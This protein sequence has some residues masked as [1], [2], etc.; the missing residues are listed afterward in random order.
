MLASEA[1]AGLDLGYAKEDGG[2]AG[3]FLDFAASAR[4]LGMGRAHL[5]V[6]DDAGAVYWNPAGLA[7]ID[8]Q[9]VVS[10]YSFL[11]EDTGFGYASFA[12]PTVGAGTLGIGLVSLRSGGF[13]RRDASGSQNGSFDVSEMGLLLG[14]GIALTERLAFGSTLKIVRQSVDNFA[15][16]GYGLDLG[17]M[18]RLSPRLQAGF[19]LRNLIAPSVKLR[20]HAD[21]YP[22]DIR[23]GLK[24]TP[25][26]KLLLA[27]DLIQTQDRSLKLNLGGEYSINQLLV[28]RAGLN[29]TEMS[30]G[31]G[32]RLQDFG[33]DYAF[34][35]H[36]AVS[37]V[38]DLG[39]SHRFGFHFNFAPPP[40]SL[41][42]VD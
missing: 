40:P 14:H 6:T 39:A 22:R 12:Q 35:Y 3:A 41:F 19:A 21:D 36:D 5:A 17:L 30:A 24:F 37:G 34:G 11:Q 31:L 27:S 15:G 26:K 20:N 16:T 33:I 28:L 10:M 42:F 4:S 13:E 29:E 8:R 7:R 23:A 9:D 18:S 25:N 38:T 1:R 32:F 2:Q